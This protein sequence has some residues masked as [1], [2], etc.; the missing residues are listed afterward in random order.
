M[1]YGS[2]AFSLFPLCFYFRAVSRRHIAVILVMSVLLL[3]LGSG[4]GVETLDAATHPA[5]DEDQWEAPFEVE[6]SILLTSF[7]SLT[8]GHLRKLADSLELVA[9]TEAAKSAQWEEIEK[10]L[11]QVGEQNVEA[12]NWFALPDGSYWSVQD[13]KAAANLSDRAYFS[14]LTRGE[15]VAGDLV[16]SRATGKSVAIVAVPVFDENGD[17]VGALG[18]SVYLDQLSERISREMG[19]GDDVIFYTFDAAPLIGLNYDEALIFINP[20]EL[21]EEVKRAFEE[22]LE[23]EEGGVSYSFRGR[24]RFVLYRKSALTNWWYAVG[25]IE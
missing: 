22:M 20:M 24:E 3:V 1:K 14:K 2:Q 4:A 11:R 8:D 7:I 10:P 21:G 9:A 5:T 23:R 16:V 18:S 13:G 25:K 17:I 19:I 12:L 15:S 6:G